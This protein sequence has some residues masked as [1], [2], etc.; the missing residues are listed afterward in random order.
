MAE[1][2]ALLGGTLVIKAA[3]RAGTELLATVPLE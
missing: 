1:R 2:L 3:R